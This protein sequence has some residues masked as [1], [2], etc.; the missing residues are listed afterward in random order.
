MD[1]EIEQNPGVHAAVPLVSPPVDSSEGWGALFSRLFAPPVANSGSQVKETFHCEGSPLEDV[2]G[3]E[4]QKQVKALQAGETKTSQAF[5]Y[6]TRTIPRVTKDFRQRERA[7]CAE[8]TFNDAAA[9]V[10]TLSKRAALM[11]LLEKSGGV[12]RTCRGKEGQRSR[13]V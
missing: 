3:K 12:P 2:K 13:E 8:Q 5:E 11:A 6:A 9:S 1:K 4:G 10:Q 7:R